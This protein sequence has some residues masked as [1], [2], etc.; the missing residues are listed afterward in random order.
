MSTNIPEDSAGSLARVVSGIADS[1]S[2]GGNVGETASQL[3]GNM[4]RDVVSGIDEVFKAA[5]GNLQKRSAASAGEGPLAS[6]PGGVDQAALSV[7]I[8]ALKGKIDSMRAE[9]YRLMQSDNKLDQMRGQNELEF[10]VGLFGLL[11]KMLDEQMQIQAQ[12]A[13]GV[14]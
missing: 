2:H 7:D 14:R 6:F 10:A 13:H 8:T 12:Q 3:A 4:V 11:S 9:A 5:F 1:V